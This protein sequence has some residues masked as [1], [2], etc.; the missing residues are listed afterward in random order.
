MIADG[1]FLFDDCLNNVDDKD[2]IDC[3]KWYTDADGS[4]VNLP[5]SEEN[6]LSIKWLKARGTRNPR[7]VAVQVWA[8]ITICQRRK[9]CRGPGL[10]QL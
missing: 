7:A 8:S 1:M 9:R 6:P 2:L 5:M 4:Y 10:Q 3:L